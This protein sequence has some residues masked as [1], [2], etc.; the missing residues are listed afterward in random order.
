MTKPPVMVTFS[1]GALRGDI[2]GFYYRTFIGE[3][4]KDA[5]WR[6]L[7][8]CFE[9]QEHHGAILALTPLK[10]SG[11]IARNSNVPEPRPEPPASGVAVSA[12]SVPGEWDRR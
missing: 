11:Q 1:D 7:I 4:P 3:D 10:K 2:G 8:T 9:R 5:A 6:M 12:P